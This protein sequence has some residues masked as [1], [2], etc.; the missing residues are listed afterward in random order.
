MAPVNERCPPHGDDEGET[1]MR[2]QQIDQVL[3]GAVESGGVPCV[4]AMAADDSGV[5]YE[6]AAGHRTPDSGD[7]VTPDTVLRI[8]SMTK[9]VVT[10]AALQ[11]VERGTLD[12]DAPV[13]HYRPEFADV[14]VLDGFD[15]DTPRLRPP[16]TR[17][18]VHQLITHTTGLGY[19]F[20]NADISRWEQATGNPNVLSGLNAVF[21]APMTADPG[22]QFQYGINIDWLGLVV[23]GVAGRSLDK[24]IAEHV[25]GPLGMDD[26]TWIM[27]AQQRANS[28]PVHVRG[29]DG[30]WIATDLD[31]NQSPEYWAGGHG[32]YSTPRDYLKFQRM[33]LGQGEYNGERILQPETVQGAF[34]NQIGRL[35]FPAE[36]RSADPSVTCDIALGPGL[37][38]G[39]GL[40][41]N[42]EQLPGMRAPGSGAWAGLFNTHFWVDPVSGLTASIFTQLLPFAEPSAFQLLIDYELALYA[43]R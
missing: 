5:V 34:R 4:V 2:V 41:L 22:T 31:F 15:G 32:L 10:T 20:L 9:M 25:T 6:G 11:Q 26:T 8:A 38:W 13:E 40:L 37:K 3:Q 33:L 27:S 42:E 35:E 19:W 36:I 14:G 21:Q 7:P 39:L 28:I 23:E 18:T 24:H 12:L 1:R 17:A 43:S 16:A 30:T 29:E